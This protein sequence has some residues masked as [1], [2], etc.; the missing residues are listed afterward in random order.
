MQNEQESLGDA[1]KDED[2]ST[3]EQAKQDGQDGRSGCHCAPYPLFIALQGQPVVVIGAGRVAQ[4][5]IVVL[6]ERGARVRVIAPEATEEVASLAQKGAIAWE[7]RA[8]REG[9][10]EGSLI[11]FAATADRSVNERVFSEAQARTM[12]VNV[13]DV[14]ELCNAIVPSVMRRGRLQIAV[15]TDGASPETAK[16]IR[17]ELEERYPAWWETY[18]DSLAEMRLEIKRR[19]SGPASRRKPLYQAVLDDDAI[20][21]AAKRGEKIDASETFE[22]VVCP[23]LAQEP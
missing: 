7:K 20:L 1:A 5:K 22:R 18:M 14:P 9:D 10:L 15:S 8:Y 3:P 23:M 21:G 12:L 13:V 2:R 16:N 11:A 6:L 19:V 4:R 17:K